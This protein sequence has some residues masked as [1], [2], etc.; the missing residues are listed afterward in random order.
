MFDDII[1]HAPK[2]AQRR[3]NEYVQYAMEEE[4]LED[5]PSKYG[6]KDFKEMTSH[7][8]QYECG[9]RYP[10][11]DQLI[12]DYKLFWEVVDTETEKHR[13]IGGAE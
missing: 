5:L 2:D 1:K 12:K 11:E 7:L 3:I 10:D 6:V 8:V 9:Q 13:V 4:T